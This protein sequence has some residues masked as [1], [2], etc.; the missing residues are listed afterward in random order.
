MHASVS[1][2]VFGFGKKSF[3]PNTVD[4]ALNASDA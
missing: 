3:I 2:P 4:I 1:L